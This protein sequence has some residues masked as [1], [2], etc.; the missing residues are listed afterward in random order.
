MGELYRRG[1]YLGGVC[2]GLGIWTGTPS[3]IWRF[4]F[5]IADV[6]GLIYLLLWMILPRK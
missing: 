6:G 2:E 5:I 3:I 4:L 1:G